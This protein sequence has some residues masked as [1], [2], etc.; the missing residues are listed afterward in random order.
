MSLC[1]LIAL[2]PAGACRPALDL[3]P[4]ASP[5]GGSDAGPDESDAGATAAEADTPQKPP[6]PPL[7]ECSPTVAPAC[8]TH[9]EL[10][11]LI[12]VIWAHVDPPPT[13]LLW[14]NGTM[15]ERCVVDAA[16]RCAMAL[17]TEKLDPK[18]AAALLTRA[19][20]LARIVS[21]DATATL[22]LLKRAVRLDPT[23]LD[24]R[25]HI[26]R[27]LFDLDRHSQA[28]PHLERMRNLARDA[29]DVHSEA[30]AT[31]LLGRAY[32]VVGRPADA[33]KVLKESLAKFESS[34]DEASRYW[35]CPY[36]ALGELYSRTGDSA[37]SADFFARAADREPGI[38]ESQ[39]DAAIAFYAAGD[40]TRAADYAAR[41][42]ALQ[43]QRVTNALRSTL[44]ECS[45]LT[46]AGTPPTPVQR[47][48]N[49]AALADSFRG[50][51]PDAALRYAQRALALEDTP[52]LR[53]LVARLESE[54]MASGDLDDA[55]EAFSNGELW[56]AEGIV[57]T[58]LENSSDVAAIVVLGLI[59]LYKRDY[60][61]AMVILSRGG[62]IR[63]NDPGVSIGFG[64]ERLA[65]RDFAGA[66]TF[67]ES[68]SKAIC[69]PLPPKPTPYDRFMCRMADL[70]LAWTASNT[71]RHEDAIK[72]FDRVLADRP[73]DLLALVGKGNAL[74]GLQRIDEAAK[75][76]QRAL[77][78][79]PNSPYALA[80]LGFVSYNKGDLAAAEA[81]FKRALVED[82]ENYTCPFEGL[83]LIYLRQGKVEE[84]KRHL[85]RAIEINP[86]IEYKK[87]NALA[88][89]RLSEGRVEEARAL[90]QRSIENFPYDPE[91]KAMLARLPPATA[92]GA[93]PPAQGHP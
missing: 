66:A 4:D 79:Q 46:A 62:S 89:I 53:A 7:P 67:F 90:L 86:D 56:R 45:R 13:L 55:V 58:L 25:R 72:A 50:N 41:G 15:L 70:G 22:N 20:R 38:A 19:A 65:R 11:A 73:N 69:N 36:Q 57:R 80:E 74:S 37:K 16:A 60:E 84:A 77:K 61:E 33:E 26:S 68:G 54:V 24:S 14:T 18:S 52:A 35:G 71:N 47:A 12:D 23:S 63:P 78:H 88:T 40:C 6:P 8:R 42:E 9:D 31:E 75:L 10:L 1:L 64:H 34:T 49:A 59:R 48:R 44:E 92:G 28:I 83:G 2:Q 43:A 30:F 76:F 87:F 82:D 85:Q 21:G 32:L 3:A 5:H 39:Y 81:L 29:A 17:P 93:A 91:A 27:L 51:Q